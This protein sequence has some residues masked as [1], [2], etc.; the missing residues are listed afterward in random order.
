MDSANAPM[1]ARGVPV[2]LAR[3]VRLFQHVLHCADREQA[4][5]EDE[6]RRF[7][8]RGGVRSRLC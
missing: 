3:L 2:V 4:G 7:D 1:K 6:S 5:D 8:G